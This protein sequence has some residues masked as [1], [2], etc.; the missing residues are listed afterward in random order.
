MKFYIAIEGPIGVG[1]TTLVK[2]FQSK[3]GAQTILYVFDNPYLSD[4][5]RDKPNAAFRT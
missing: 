3:A 2:F 5:Y 4:F 1:K